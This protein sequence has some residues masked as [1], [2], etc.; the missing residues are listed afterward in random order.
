LT[1]QALVPPPASAGAP[2]CGVPLH[3]GRYA[4]AQ[5]CSR[6]SRHARACFCRRGAHGSLLR[7]A[8]QAAIDK[9][10]TREA[11]L[12]AIDQPRDSLQTEGSRH[13]FSGSAPPCSLP[14]SSVI[15]ILN[16]RATDDNTIDSVPSSTSTAVIRVRVLWGKGWLRLLTVFEVLLEVSPLR[17]R[18]EKR[19]QLPSF[20]F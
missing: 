16:I 8:R 17:P 5:T 12:A 11:D 2:M 14:S 13:R 6:S 9:T 10:R 3:I 18:G 1:I 20:R 4:A 15:G 19:F 7:L